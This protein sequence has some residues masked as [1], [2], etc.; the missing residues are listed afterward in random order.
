[1]KRQSHTFDGK[2][3]FFQKIHR[4][5]AMRLF[6]AWL[7]ASL[8]VGAATAYLEVR[9]V[10]DLASALA[11]SASDSLQ[12]H[13]AKDG[14]QHVESLNV[15]LK[16][17]LEQGYVQAQVANEL[18]LVI[19]KVATI[20]NQSNLFARLTSS[21]RM[22][23][24]L[25]SPRV[26]HRTLWFA[27]ELVVQVNVPLKDSVGN[28]IGHFNGAYRVDPATRKHA[29]TDLVRN[30]SMVLLSILATTF[31]I[32]PVIIGL[33]R[34]VMQLSA[35]LMRSNL[36]LM[37]VLG[38]A[39]AKRDSDTDLHNYRVCLYSIFF[40]EALGLPDAEIRAVIV[41]AFLHDVGKI[42]ISDAILL[43]KGK[44]TVEEFSIMKTHVQLGM[45]I[46]AKSSWIDEAKD[47][48]E[49][50]HERFDGSGYQ[51]GLAG[52]SIPLA[53]R[54]FA[55]VDVFDALTSSRPYKE[56]FPLKEAV[57][58]LVESSGSHFDP[59]LVATFKNI[60]TS[61]HGELANRPERYLR[62]LLHG[63]VTKYFLT[64]SR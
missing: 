23:E 30:V 41:G 50:H 54:L 17:L 64:I 40:A 15:A 26:S 57:H 55:I 31:L 39:V 7:V 9:R 13:V 32:Y 61:L 37:E 10:D 45:D 3:Q 24:S 33:H 60:A 2:R 58:I 16:K 8:L 14:V 20:G 43:K 11:L 52:E 6:F 62:Q 38:S 4:Q 19:S 63:Q 12:I 34:G 46:V 29:Q 59:R 36:E 18:G 1:M 21:K 47:V 44:L 49:F 35:D 48:I 22:P 56:A 51:R 53:A 25:M 5:V 42:G 28:S 27:S